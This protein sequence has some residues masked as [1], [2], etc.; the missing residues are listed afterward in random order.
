MKNFSGQIVFKTALAL[1][2]LVA[3]CLCAPAQTA[4]S[5][6]P[7]PVADGKSAQLVKVSAVVLD[8]KNNFVNDLRAEDFV[9]TDSGVAQPVTFFALEDLP[10][11][12]TLLVDNTG[13]LREML[14]HVL[15]TGEAIVA[16]KRPQDE[17]SVVRFVSRDKI[18]LLQ[19]FTRNQ[20]A[21]AAALD[22]MYVEGGATAMLEALYVTAEAVAARTP[23]TER[24]RAL[25]LVTDGGE[26]D[27]RS[28][29][30]ELFTLLRREHVRVF[31]L[32]LT[33]AMS[34]DAFAQ[35][36]GGRKK[37][38]ELLEMLARETGGRAVFPKTPS[39][40]GAAAAALNRELQMPEY[41]LG[42]TPNKA[43]N[44]AKPGMIQVKL[45]D[46][47]MTGRGK[48]HLHGSLQPH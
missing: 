19:D 27:P 33:D 15:R 12:Y 37:S 14:D 48:L 5:P 45:A 28:K 43:T 8:E 31:V 3:V 47:A 44:N 13:S 30:D 21:L 10:L 42:Y 39:E 17:M 38:R 2:L 4:S 46:S 24:R 26:R 41:V 7:A 11:S 29:P 9:L 1:T 20:N 36:K 6:S 34:S 22:Q 25:V 35:V 16:G 40:F 23:F 32:G 18:E